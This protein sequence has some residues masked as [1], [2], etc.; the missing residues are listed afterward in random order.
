MRRRLAPIQAL[1]FAWLLA[2]KQENVDDLRHQL[3]KRVAWVCRYG[4]GAAFVWQLDG[5]G[6]D[7]FMR[8]TSELIG[9]EN[10]DS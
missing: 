4:R 2:W 3:W 1:Y 10:P 7:D 8:A 9:E 6:M 5:A